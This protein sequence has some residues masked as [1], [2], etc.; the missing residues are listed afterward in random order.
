MASPKGRFE[1]LEVEWDADEPPGAPDTRYLVDRSQSILSHNNSPDLPFDV[2]LNPYRGCEHG[3]SYCYARPTHEYLGFSAGLDFETRILVKPRAAELLRRELDRSSWRP[4]TLALSGVTDPYQPVER[5]L[6]I[7]GA[8]LEVLAQ[9]RNPVVIVT[10]NHLVTRDL[11]ALRELAR[12][13]AVGVVL[14]I[15][16]LDPSL[17]RVL[18]PRA[19]SPKRRLR[20]IAELSDAGIPCG[21]FVAPL[22]PGLTDHELPAILEAAVEAGASAAHWILLRLPFSLRDQFTAWLRE[23]R[24]LRA[25]RVLS[26]LRELRGG[27]LN[28]TAWGRRMRGEGVFADQIAALHRT[29]CRRLG[30]EKGRFDLS[31]E[32][33]RRPGGVQL[34][35]L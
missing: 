35:L 28:D 3:C 13:R 6:G 9:Y 7:T 4:R 26:R 27:D 21:V 17:S 24:P 31:S 25:D 22:I 1:R 32:A 15:T 33:F 5:K 8:C 11:D 30:I 19:S 10:K 18:E 14:S 16:T 29:T 2:S 23:H 12:H 34:P 20:A